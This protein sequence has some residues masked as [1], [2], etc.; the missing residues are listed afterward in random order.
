M[1]VWKNYCSQ[2]VGAARLREG[3]GRITLR[4]KITNTGPRPPRL[5]SAHHT[6]ANPSSPQLCSTQLALAKAVTR[7]YPVF[8]F[9]K[10]Q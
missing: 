9:V 8:K 6:A 2:E 5:G 1:Q 10:A 3:S 4:D 7:D